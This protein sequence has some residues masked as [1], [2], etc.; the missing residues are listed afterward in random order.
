MLP[1][2]NSDEVVIS[3][4]TSATMCT[5]DY[6]EHLT[7]RDSQKLSKLD[8]WVALQEVRDQKANGNK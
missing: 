2:I 4:I 7:S 3:S 6:S 1:I 5:L 8:R